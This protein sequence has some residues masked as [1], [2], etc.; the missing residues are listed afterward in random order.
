VRGDR[1]IKWGRVQHLLAD[2]LPGTFGQGHDE[3]FDWV[4]RHGLVRQALD[5]I[6]GE[7]GWRTE[8]RDDSSSV[9][10]TDRA[11]PRSTV[12]EPPADRSPD[13]D[14]GPPPGEP[15]F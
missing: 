12:P 4:Y 1:G 6:L 10:A 9:F 14:L 3:R 11:R 8:R 5:E 13:D 2:N 7:N 15:P